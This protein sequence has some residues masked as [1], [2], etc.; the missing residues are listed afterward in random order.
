MVPSIDRNALPHGQHQTY[1]FGYESERTIQF[2]LLETCKGYHHLWHPE[3]SVIRVRWYVVRVNNTQ[4]EAKS[5]RLTFN[6]AYIGNISFWEMSSHPL[7]K[8]RIA[9]EP[10]ISLYLHFSSP[11]VRET[12]NSYVG[13]QLW[14]SQQRVAYISSN[15]AQISNRYNILDNIEVNFLL[16]FLI[17]L[18]LFSV[19]SLRLRSRYVVKIA[20]TVAFRSEHDPFLHLSFLVDEW[21][22]EWTNRYN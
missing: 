14:K 1:L 17:F 2:N 7:V 22:D 6:S 15:M 16:F 8:S 9:K 11:S 18:Y 20:F 13:M 21:M 4:S 19:L 5:S 12:I 10:C 3:I